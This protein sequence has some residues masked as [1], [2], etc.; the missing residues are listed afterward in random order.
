MEKLR[1]RRLFF[2]IETSPN[3]VYSWRSGYNLT[4]PYENIIKERAVICV[5]WKWEGESLVHTLTWDK[6]QNDKKVV[7]KFVKIL[8]QADEIIAHNG[9]RFDMK[10]LRGR[11]IK[12][13]I[14]MRDSYTTTDTLK[15]ARKGFNFN[16]NRL[17]YLAKYLGVGAKTSHSGFQLWVDVMDKVDGALEQMVQYC[18]NDVVILEKVFNK[19]KNYTKP[20]THHA[21]LKGAERWA[22]PDCGNTDVHLNKTRTTSSGIIKRE[23]QCKDKKCGRNY[24][25]SDR[26]YVL[27]IK[28]KEARR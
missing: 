14:E 26:G 24:T 19:M 5:S 10:W 12:H 23:M 13:G 8:N 2:D 17:D 16:S 9:D 22:C 11:A 6:R 3:I 27:Y 7:E 21:S 25:I 1:R 20:T 4:I 15:L 18:E 28:Y